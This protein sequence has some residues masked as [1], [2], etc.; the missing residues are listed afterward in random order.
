MSVQQQERPRSFGVGGAATCPNCHKPTL[1]AV[2]EPHP[3]NREI[4]LQ[5]FD[6]ANCG[7][8]RTKILSLKTP[9]L[10]MAAWRRAILTP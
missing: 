8:V 1:Q 4:A 3:T 5:N 9:T 10:E 2:I 7:P 6:C